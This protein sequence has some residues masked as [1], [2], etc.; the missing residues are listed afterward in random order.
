MP[1]TIEQLD[2]FADVMLFDVD[3]PIVE[4]MKM[5]QGAA[6]MYYAAFH[7]VRSAMAKK[8][9]QPGYKISH[10]K[11]IDWLMKANSRQ[12]RELG[13]L[14]HDGRSV[15]HQCDYDLSASLPAHQFKVTASEL[16]TYVVKKATT[17]DQWVQGETKPLPPSGL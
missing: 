5:R 16:R 3:R 8:V 11:L 6:R 12:L 2:A 9:G 4:E 17:V 10:N 1:C 15:R 13:A 7:T 14:M